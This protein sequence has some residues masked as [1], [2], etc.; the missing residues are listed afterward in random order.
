MLTYFGK[1]F[2]LSECTF[3]SIF[4]ATYTNHKRFAFALCSGMHCASILGWEMHTYLI[5]NIL[6]G[7]NGIPG[8]APAAVN[9]LGYCTIDIVFRYPYTLI[10]ITEKR[11]NFC[12]AVIN[13]KGK[14]LKTILSCQVQRMWRP[15]GDTLKLM[16]D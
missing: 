10:K 8:V 7:R 5:Y 12:T 13:I 15:P 11:L 14:K 3:D 16:E 1:D 4:G 9:I 6:F 2:Q